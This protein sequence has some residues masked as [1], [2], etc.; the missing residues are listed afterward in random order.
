MELLLLAPDKKPGSSIDLSHIAKLRL[1]GVVVIGIEA[2][3]HSRG[4]VD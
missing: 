1:S 4:L 3:A 2:C